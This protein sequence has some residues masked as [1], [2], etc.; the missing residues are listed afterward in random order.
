MQNIPENEINRLYT[1]GYTIQEISKIFNINRGVV[2]RRL[3]KNNI[4]LRVPNQKIYFDETFFT[5][6]DSPEKEYWLGFICA[7]GFHDKYQFKVKLCI[8][9]KEHLIKL[10][11][12]MGSNHHIYDTKN[13]TS[14]RI[15]SK[16]LCDILDGHGCMTR[17]SLIIKYP[18]INPVLNRHFIRGVFDGDGCFYV[19]S[20]GNARAFSIVSGS[21]DFVYEIHS[22][23][24]SE[25]GIQSHLY[26]RT[27][28]QKN[29]IYA[30]QITKK[31]DLEK[32]F[33]YLY[34]GSI[35]LSRKYTKFYN[36]LQKQKDQE[37]K[38]LNTIELIKID[39]NQNNLSMKDVA[40]KYDLSIRTIRLYIL[41]K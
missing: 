23:L 3:I 8:K 25:V 40:K 36:F 9:D 28:K 2:R 16:Q 32:L 29:K 21:Y 18:N 31:R 38:K 24:T 4:I 12:A 27:L 39:Y 13:D 7:D 17:K 22:L 6:I 11:E 14:F 10:K 20:S 35:C 19:S 30:I 5:E 33:T 41:G 26:E 15:C 37:Q 1:D 34:D